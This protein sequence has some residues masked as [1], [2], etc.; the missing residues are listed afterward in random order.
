MG[1]RKLLGEG[2]LTKNR[3]G[4]KIR[5]LLCNDIL[6]MTDLDEK[7]LY[8]MVRRLKLLPIICESDFHAKPLQVA[9]LEVR[10][11]PGGR[12]APSDRL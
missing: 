1:P 2:I 8:K 3:S 9:D 6:L 5:V 7:Q 12:G 10:D 4:R 11:L